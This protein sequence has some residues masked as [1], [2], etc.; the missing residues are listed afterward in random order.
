MVVFDTF[1]MTRV[2]EL[3]EHIGSAQYISTLDLGKGYWQIPVAHRDR[4]K[5]AFGIAWGLY[6][7][8]HMPFGL[9]GAEL[10][11]KGP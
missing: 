1:A 9:H 7:F 11:L 5:T 3:V 6:K 2:T 8:V 10:A 4:H